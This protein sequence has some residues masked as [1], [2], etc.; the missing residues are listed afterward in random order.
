MYLAAAACDTRDVIILLRHG[1]TPTNASARL[2]GQ[3]D[4]PLDELGRTQASAAGDYIRSRWKIDEVIT[5]SLIRTRETAEYAGFGGQAVIDDRWREIDFGSYDLRRISDVV[6]ELGNAW[7]EDIGYV[8][9]GGESMLA[10]H[11]RVTS[12]CVDVEERARDR[13]VLVVSHSTPIKSASVWAMGGTASQILKLSLGVGSVSV[14]G[15]Y[16]GELVLK[17]FNTQVMPPE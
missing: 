5:S 16:H 13:N 17:E 1:R 12:A 10:L 9:D 6:Q 2:Q 4:S 11:E 15:Y 3:Q 7:T 14:I 8:P